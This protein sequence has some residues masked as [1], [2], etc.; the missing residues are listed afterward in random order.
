MP[1]YVF[2]IPGYS[3]PVQRHHGQHPGAV[4]LF[5]AQG[6][7]IY[8]VS[9]GRVDGA[10]WDNTGGFHVAISNPADGRDYYYAHLAGPP[11]VAVG[12]AAQ[13]GQRLGEV[14]NTG[15]AITT[16]PHLH[17]GI[18]YG[19]IGGQGPAGG[20]GRD[21]DAVSFL[22]GL[23]LA[24]GGVDLPAGPGPTPQPGGWWGPLGTYLAGAGRAGR[25]ALW[26]L[27]LALRLFGR[28]VYAALYWLYALVFGVRG[29]DVR[30]NSEA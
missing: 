16:P 28:S 2:P 24:P 14:G 27:A 21:F 13:P 6:T 5:A 8:A 9:G 7:P 12:D 23:Q 1:R 30:L 26:L 25:A 15:N 19:I 17:L 4:D 29:I 20:S 3:G 18:G 22:R 11:R 10:G